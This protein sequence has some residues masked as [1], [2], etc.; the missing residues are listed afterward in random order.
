V[1]ECGLLSARFYC[2]SLQ[3]V[4]LVYPWDERTSHGIGSVSRTSEKEFVVG[5]YLVRNP[6]KEFSE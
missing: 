5:L 4:G 3:R 1:K 2:Y 6:L